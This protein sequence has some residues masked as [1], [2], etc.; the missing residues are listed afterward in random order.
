MNKFH[1]GCRMGLPCPETEMSGLQLLPEIVHSTCLEN[2]RSSNRNCLR[3]P[4]ILMV[5]S[6]R[7]ILYL[8][9]TKYIYIDLSKSLTDAWLKYY[10]TA[11]KPQTANR[12][13]KSQP[14][15]SGETGLLDSSGPLFNFILTDN[16]TEQ[17][18]G[19]RGSLY[20]VSLTVVMAVAIR[21]ATSDTL[22]GMM[23]VFVVLARLPN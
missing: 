2:Q 22:L 9:F 17:G 10:G 13:N 3:T 18:K 5:R 12:E 15:V 23:I 1:P 19:L 4:S 14:V 11:Q 7:K 16:N 8:L 20:L 6:Q 21:P